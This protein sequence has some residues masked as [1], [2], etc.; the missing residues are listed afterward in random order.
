MNPGDPELRR[1]LLGER[2][3]DYRLWRA[4]RRTVGLQVGR[5]GLTVRAPLR[6]SVRDLHQVLQEKAGWILT[7][8]AEWTRR[9]AQAPAAAWHDG[10]SILIDGRAHKLVL[11]PAPRI[12]MALDAQGLHLGLPE[13]GDEQAVARAVEQ[14]LR[15]RA[16]QTFAP[17][18]AEFAATLGL[19]SPRLI[20]YAPRTL[21]GSCNRSGVIRLHW[22]LIQLPP[23]LADYII[24]HE[25]AHL[26]EMNHSPRFWAVVAR[27]YPDFRAARAAVRQFEPLLH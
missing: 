7:K 21:W 25:V 9:S 19:P 27:L 1:I 13:P 17:R 11:G 12:S 8:L 24:A 10:A 16:A 3:V 5:D 22:R 18:L 20:I 2:E 14:F 26:A 4:R 15:R 23:E 6:I